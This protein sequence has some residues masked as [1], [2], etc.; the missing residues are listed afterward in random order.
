VGLLV[1]E[2]V[3]KTLG[4]QNAL[5][6]FQKTIGIGGAYPLLEVGGQRTEL[7]AEKPKDYASLTFLAALLPTL[8]TALF[9]NLSVPAVDVFSQHG[10][11]LLQRECCGCVE[12]PART[13]SKSREGGAFPRP[14]TLTP[15][16]SP[17]RTHAR[18]GEGKRQVS[19]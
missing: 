8:L 12:G 5:A 18:P 14:K 13:P 1:S 15:G 2:D 11:E 6:P 4:S 17:T 10:F 7:Q 16:P 3:L 19:S 9:S